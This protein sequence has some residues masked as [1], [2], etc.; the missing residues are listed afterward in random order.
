M[1][2]KTDTATYSE[3]PK[4][5]QLPTAGGKYIDDLSGSGIMPQTYAKNDTNE[6]G[7]Q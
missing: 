1:T 6:R 2:I 4:V 7:T 3:N 5:L